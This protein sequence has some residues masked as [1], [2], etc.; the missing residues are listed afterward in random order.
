M[1]KL[2]KVPLLDLKAQYREIRT[3]ILEA[4]E[5]VCDEQGFVLG[6]GVAELEQALARFVGTAHAVG[7]ASGSDALL[8]SLMAT[9][10][11][12]GD[13]VITVPFTFFA[14]TGVI[15]RLGAQPVFV[16]I[17]PDSF[18]MDPS[19]IEK[20]VTARTKAIIPVH[21]FG[22]CA[23]MDAIRE[24][25]KHRG[26]NVIEDACQA[27]GASRNQVR[28]GAMGEAGCFSFF[29]TKNLGGFGDG[30][31]VTMNDPQLKDSVSM[32]RVHGSRVRYLH[33]CVGVNSRLDAL[34]AAVL[35]V[36]FNYLDR[37]VEGRKRNATR[38]EQFFK[39]ANVLDHVVPPKTDPGNAHV[40][41]QYTIRARQRDALRAHLKDKGIGTEIYY[42]VPLHLQSCYRGL[43]YRKGDLPVSEQASEEVLSLPIY[44]ELTD[45]QLTYVVDS[46]ADYY[47]GH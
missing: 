7:V 9:G 27:F 30:G 35:R 33:E 44:A 43:G 16:D 46:V 3:E 18:N 36:K 11:G 20:R 13:E 26:L 8:L 21:L 47:R 19:Q 17:R 41:N 10:V 34:Q 15:S 6:P 42:P 38:Y 31:L 12:W 4:I 28:A 22:Q 32:L 23:E 39:Q 45:E 29:P 2:V 5:K 24:I 1:E 40:F 14:T 25:A 37:W